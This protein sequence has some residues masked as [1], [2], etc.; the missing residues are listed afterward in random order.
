M[1][2][3][4]AQHIK[5]GL[6]KHLHFHIITSS[7]FAVSEMYTFWGPKEKEMSLD[8]ISSLAFSNCHDTANK[9]IF[10]KNGRMLFTF[11][12]V[13]NSFKSRV[14]SLLQEMVR[15]IFIN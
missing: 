2:S 6:D 11:K 5:K 4:C 1:S 14:N 8:Y 13:I 9:Y 15:D 12:R 3:H 7:D 10:V